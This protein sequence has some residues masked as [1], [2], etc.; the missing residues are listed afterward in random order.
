MQDDRVALGVSRIKAKPGWAG[1]R[2]VGSKGKAAYHCTF[3]WVSQVYNNCNQTQSC[4]YWA[5]QRK[6]AFSIGPLDPC[7][8]TQRPKVLQRVSVAK[9]SVGCNTCMGTTTF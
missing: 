5:W 8:W 1:H 2:E 7:S 9:A 6:E 4:R 3:G